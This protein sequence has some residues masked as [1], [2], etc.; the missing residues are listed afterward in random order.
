MKK[1]ETEIKHYLSMMGCL[2]IKTMGIFE[3]SCHAYVHLAKWTVTAFIH[4]RLY[5]CIRKY[6]CLARKELIRATLFCVIK[7]LFPFYFGFIPK[8]FIIFIIMKNFTALHEPKIHKEEHYCKG[9]CVKI[10]QNRPSISEAQN[11]VF[12]KNI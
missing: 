10:Y 9:F 6:A 8:L 3:I 7:F 2:S 4:M 1:G 11:S 5:Q 12:N